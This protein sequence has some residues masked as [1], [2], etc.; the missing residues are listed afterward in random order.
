[1]ITCWFR[2]SR[3]RLPNRFAFLKTCPFGCIGCVCPQGNNELGHA[4][5]PS[6]VSSQMLSKRDQQVFWRGG[7]NRDEWAIT[8]M[9]LVTATIGPGTK[10]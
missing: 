3:Q 7:G 6:S 8:A 4:F 5:L 1:V 2:P 10:Q 9:A